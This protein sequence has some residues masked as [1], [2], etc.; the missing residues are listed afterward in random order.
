LGGVERIRLDQ[1]AIE[2][3]AAQK[4]LKSSP[5]TGFVGV[6]SLLGQGHAKGPG[7]DGDLSDIDEVGRRP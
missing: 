4:F 3:Q 2:I 1:H 5:L 7:V 6:V